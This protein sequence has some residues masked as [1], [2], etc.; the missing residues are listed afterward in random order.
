MQQ[1][2]HMRKRQSQ[3]E[4]MDEKVN[5]EKRKRQL[6]EVL[7]RIRVSQAQVIPINSNCQ[8]LWA[9]NRQTVN[10]LNMLISEERQTSSA[11]QHIF[12]HLIENVCSY[13]S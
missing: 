4:N 8:L 6:A 3:I 12:I 11:I 2:F 7:G 13:N 5:G 9:G 10:P 1:S